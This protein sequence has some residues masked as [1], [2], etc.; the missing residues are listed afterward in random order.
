MSKS[1]G[2][3]SSTQGTATADISMRVSDEGSEPADAA[4]ARHTDV[5]SVVPEP[6]QSN[7]EVIY[8]AE[9][10]EMIKSLRRETPNIV[11][12]SMKATSAVYLVLVFARVVDISS[13]DFYEILLTMCLLSFVVAFVRINILKSTLSH[14]KTVTPD[15]VIASRG[16]DE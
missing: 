16:T 3:E 6:Q 13:S 1:P 7:H 12:S 14:A 11:M 4:E 2:G 5:I 10:Y 8:T 15:P 9:K